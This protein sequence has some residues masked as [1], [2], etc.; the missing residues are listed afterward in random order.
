MQSVPFTTDIVSSGLDQGEDFHIAQSVIFC[1]VVFRSLFVLFS[2]CW[3]LNFLF[4][5]DLR[6][7]FTPLVPGSFSSYGVVFC[8]KGVNKSRKSK[9]NRKFNGQQ[10]ENKTNNDLKT[11][12]QNITD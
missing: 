7:L 2:F 6:L 10:K 4:C 8:N 1:V 12:T 11:T 5:F 9:Q 3:P